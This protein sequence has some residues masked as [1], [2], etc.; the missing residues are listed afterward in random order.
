MLTCASK[1]SF[2][3]PSGHSYSAENNKEQHLLQHGGHSILLHVDI[4]KQY[5][6]IKNNNYAGGP[7]LS[8]RHDSSV[9]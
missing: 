3:P 8:H 5:C 6:L 9:W 7:A 4:C 2:P 1:L